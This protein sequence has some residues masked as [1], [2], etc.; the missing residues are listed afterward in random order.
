MLA[1]KQ[2][3]ARIEWSAI[4]AVGVAKC[5]MAKF[6]TLEKKDI[7]KIRIKKFFKDT[8]KFIFSYTSAD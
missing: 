3:A 8:Y 5:R 7:L 6:R 1:A 2:V 4:L